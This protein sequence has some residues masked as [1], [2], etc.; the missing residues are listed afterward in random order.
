MLQ[1]HSECKLRRCCTA[2]RAPL[3]SG[4]VKQNA[5]TNAAAPWVHPAGGARR[6][7]VSPCTAACPRPS[8]RKVVSGRVAR[9]PSWR[10]SPSRGWRRSAR[11][12]GYT[13]ASC[14][15]LFRFE[16]PD[17]SV[18]LPAPE[19]EQFVR[20][21]APLL[22]VAHYPTCGRRCLAPR[23]SLA[24]R[25][26]PR[27]HGQ[28]CRR[29]RWSC[30]R[31]SGTRRA[32]RRT[33]SACSA[34]GRSQGAATSP[35]RSARR[36]GRCPVARAARCSVAAA[37]ASSASTASSRPRMRG[38]RV[39]ASPSGSAPARRSCWPQAAS[40]PPCR[41][42][43]A[44]PRA[45]QLEA[46]VQELDE[47]RVVTSLA[48]HVG[49]RCGA[50]LIDSRSSARLTAI[51]DSI[52]QTRARPTATPQTFSWMSSS[53]NFRVPFMRC[54]EL[55]SSRFPSSETFT[56]CRLGSRVVMTL[57]CVRPPP[58][59]GRSS[60]MARPSHQSLSLSRLSTTTR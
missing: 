10:P 44:P 13:W 1:K 49:A 21:S 58:P 24:Q 42:R 5:L 35:A 47:A 46:R 6:P 50:S 3:D 52:E 32:R 30:G 28:L 45:Q 20:A 15:S 11:H 37:R 26:S 17:V 9:A 14:L 18:E 51:S 60:V 43:R 25:W 8:G 4:H 36:R 2:P 54:M 55:G 40:R 48:D 31:R 29:S 56:P 33:Q 16:V 39:G 23:S 38:Q 53:L 34:A 19:L 41:A 27:R 59:R 22:V 57:T 12:H 7:G